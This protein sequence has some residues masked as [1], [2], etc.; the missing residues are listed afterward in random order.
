MPIG[1]AY[2]YRDG[3]RARNVRIEEMVD[4]P[5]DRSTFVW[6]D[7][8]DPTAEEMELLA[9]RYCLHALAVEA[10]L[11]PDQSPRLNIYGDQLF[12]VACSARLGSERI[13]YGET[14]IFVGHSHVICVRVGGP[15][16]EMSLRD[17]VEAAPTILA[18]GVDHVL[19]AILDSIVDTYFPLVEAMEEEVIEMEQH[20]LKSFLGPGE[21]RRI[22]GLRHDLT[23][24]NR[25]LRS[26]GEVTSKLVSLDLPCLDP[27][28][29]PYFSDAL[30]HIRHVQTT[31][32]S[33][34]EI[35]TVV[36][37]IS[38]LL[39][40]QR[41]GAITRQLA[42]WAAILAVPTAIAGIYGMNFDHMPELRLRGGYFAVLALMAG[43]CTVLYARFKRAGWL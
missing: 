28:V 19:H 42:A 5:S 2:L 39:E 16:G 26:M 36:F 41:T 12:M 9:K 17:Q 13:V 31:V 40:Q 34:R 6:I 35:L 22:F 8:V 21:V 25:V 23:R 11:K 1:A 14:A 38:S 7:A 30:D 18:H 10:A 32:D 27:D 4:C 37:E 15:G 24:F 33:L 43:I 3:Q 29:K 20:T